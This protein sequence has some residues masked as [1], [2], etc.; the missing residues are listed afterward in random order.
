[1]WKSLI[2]RHLRNGNFALT[3]IPRSERFLFSA[4]SLRCDRGNGRNDGEDAFGIVKV[5]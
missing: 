3:K 5:Y 1:M 2:F 4:A